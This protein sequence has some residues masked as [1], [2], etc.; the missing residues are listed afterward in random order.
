[1][2]GGM[3]ISTTHR[4]VHYEFCHHIEGSHCPGISGAV[5]KVENALQTLMSDFSVKVSLLT[6]LDPFSKALLIS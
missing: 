4:V 5:L 3:E 2:A 1:M 6:I